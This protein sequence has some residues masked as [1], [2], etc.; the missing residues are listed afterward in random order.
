M[1][2]VLLSGKG[3]VVQGVVNKHFAKHLLAAIDDL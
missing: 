3:Q 1:S 2:S